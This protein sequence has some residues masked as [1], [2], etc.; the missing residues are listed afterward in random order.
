M[1][2]CCYSW[3]T[4]MFKLNF[5]AK[6]SLYLFEEGRCQKDCTMQ[7]VMAWKT[8]NSLY[9]WESCW[10]TKA[11]IVCDMDSF[12][13]ANSSLSKTVD[14]ISSFNVIVSFLKVLENSVKIVHFI[15]CSWILD[16]KYGKLFFSGV[17]RIFKLISLLCSTFFLLTSMSR[18][19]FF[20]L[21]QFI[22]Y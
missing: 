3:Q 16:Q 4:L 18:P 5:L 21:R 8:I 9:V 13:F 2:N 20:Y 22:C 14:F 19:F 15:Q 12:R 17:A 6:Y 7:R 11:R 10:T 1:S